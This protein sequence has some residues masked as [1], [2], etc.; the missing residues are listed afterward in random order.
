MRFHGM[1]G[2]LAKAL[3]GARGPEGGPLEATGTHV[4]VPTRFERDRLV[5]LGFAP[6][7][8]VEI[9]GFGPIA[10]A[11]R[12]ATLLASERP[13][14]IL[15]VGLAGSLDPG[16]APAG[17]A[18]E[19]SEVAVDGVGAGEGETALG[20][21]AVGFP[22]WEDAGGAV[23]DRIE[24]AASTASAL[25][26]TVCAASDSKMQAQRRRERFPGALAEDMEGFAVALACRMHGVPLR[27]IRGVSNR[28]GDRDPTTW[29]V[30]E[31]LDAVL[32]AARA[33][34]G[35]ETVE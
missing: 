21:G 9:C 22:Q 2:M 23:T 35:V 4:L 27:V 12:A 20:V 8:P 17:S 1:I 34:P 16:R 29:R 6:R 14:R 25:L 10:A 32:R 24:L 5:Q 26:L 33:V 7:C 18:I 30:D 11:A 28:A 13:G 15:L 31:A 19:F 3:E